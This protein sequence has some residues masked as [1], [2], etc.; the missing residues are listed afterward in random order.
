MKS[1][2]VQS[3]PLHGSLDDGVKGALSVAER[4][5]RFHDMIVAQT[6]EYDPSEHWSFKDMRPV[7]RPIR[8]FARVVPHSGA[9]RLFKAAISERNSQH[10]R[11]IAKKLSKM[12]RVGSKVGAVRTTTK[13]RNCIIARR[14]Y[15]D[16]GSF[17]DII[18]KESLSP[19]ELSKSLTP[20][21]ISTCRR[22]QVEL[23]REK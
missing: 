14:W 12:L 7:R 13:P 4:K 5:I 8:K 15:L 20:D 2:I 9:D 23:D 21:V 17:Y 18:Q 6:L 10:A 22:H 1:A 19:K 16:S 3:S 11:Q